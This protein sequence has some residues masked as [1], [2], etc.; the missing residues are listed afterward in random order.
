MVV[1][2]EEEEEGIEERR[3]NLRKLHE[4]NG[5]DEGSRG[6]PRAETMSQR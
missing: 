4:D 1:G 3:R 2:V 5:Y 6:D